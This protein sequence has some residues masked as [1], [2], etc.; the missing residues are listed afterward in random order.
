M[1][2]K[3]LHLNYSDDGGAGVVVSRINECMRSINYDSNI[4]V[5]EKTTTSDNVLCDQNFFDNFL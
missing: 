2:L 1:T 5:A 3:I 4:L